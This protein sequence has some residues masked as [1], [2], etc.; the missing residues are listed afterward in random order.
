MSTP[1]PDT[2]RIGSIESEPSTKRPLRDFLI[3]SDI[4]LLVFVGKCMDYFGMGAVFGFLFGGSL[5][6]GYALFEPLP[7]AKRFNP[8]PQ[9]HAAAPLTL[10]APPKEDKIKIQGVVTTD[11]TNVVKDAFQVGVVEVVSG[12][13]TNGDGTYHLEVPRQ[14]TYKVAFWKPNYENLRV[15]ELSLQ[16]GGTFSKAVWLPRNV[17][18]NA[19]AGES[20]KHAN[21]SERDKK[22]RAQ[23]AILNVEELNSMSGIFREPPGPLST[24]E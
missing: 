24:D 12:E 22:W 5:V 6:Y 1:I 7:Y 3:S 4:K 9:A 20:I 15:L 13:F 8:T 10:L 23:N 17:A 2:A 19:S 14:S 11:G 18:I 16:D 21:I